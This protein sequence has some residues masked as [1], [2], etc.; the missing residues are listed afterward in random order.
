METLKEMEEIPENIKYFGET[1]SEEIEIN[2]KADSREFK[3]ISR[4]SIFIPSRSSMPR[5]VSY[6]SKRRS[7]V[8]KSVS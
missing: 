7:T 4:N 3:P 8:N 2:T 1:I 5:R 6:T